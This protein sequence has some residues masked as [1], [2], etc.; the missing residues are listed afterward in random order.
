VDF[1]LNPDLTE[2][3]PCIVVVEHE[4]LLRSVTVE[5]LRL[6]GYF[7]I[8]AASGAE[9][10]FALAAG[11]PGDVVFS[12][13]GLPGAIDGLAL[14]RWLSQRQP[15]LPVILTT[16]HGYS[17]RQAAIRLVGERLFLSKPYSPTELVRRIRF[18]LRG[19]GW[20]YAP[21]TR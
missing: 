13:I 7:S 9:A 19:R 8:E 20:D 4:A 10:L 16:G 3:Q 21:N 1:C 15:R 2:R 11:K 17:V 5:F 12:D 18:V 6:S 14:A